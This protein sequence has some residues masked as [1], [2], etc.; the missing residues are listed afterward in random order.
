MN[1]MTK[2]ELIK[3]LNGHEWNNVEFK[4]AQRG[5]PESAYETVSAFRRLGLCEPGRRRDADGAKSMAG[6]GTSRTGVR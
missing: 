4:K 3:L 2:D 1:N 5:L 6:I